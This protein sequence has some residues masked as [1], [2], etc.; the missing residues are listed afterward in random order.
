[1]DFHFCSYLC[2]RR[3]LLHLVLW[4]PLMFPFNTIR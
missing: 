4:Y 3:P 2:Q 1:L